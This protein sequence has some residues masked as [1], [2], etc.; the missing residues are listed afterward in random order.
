MTPFV[1]IVIP[2]YNSANSIAETIEACLNQDYPKDRLEIIVAD[3][4]SADNTGEIIQNYPVRY[5]RQ[6]NMGPANARNTGWK[7]SKGEIIC[8]TDSDCVPA[9]DWISYLVKSYISDEIGGVGGTYDIA[10]TYSLLA[11]CIH[12]EIV[13]RHLRMPQ[14]VNYLGSFNLSYRRDILEQTGGFNETFLKAS[15]EDNDLAYR[16]I[17][18]GYKLVFTKDSKVAHYHPH[19]LVKYLKQQF[20]HGFWRMKLYYDNPDMA[21]GDSYGGGFDFL[22][23][24]LAMIILGLL[25]V[26]FLYPFNFLLT[27]LLTLGLTLPL[28]MTLAIIRRTGRIKYIFLWPLKFLRGYARGLGMTLGIFRFFI[29]RTTRKQEQTRI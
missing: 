19:I 6:N 28:P 11:C 8:F 1:S 17:K 2:A 25:P 4:G 20:W 27:G 15:G 7:S 18:S 5:L 16:V 26:S 14:Y 9:K 21:K 23:P 24:P 13:H 12:E 3:D 10:N 29:L 22:E